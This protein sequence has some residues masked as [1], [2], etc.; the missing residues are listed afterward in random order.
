MLSR[1]VLKE[2]GWRVTTDGARALTG[3][4]IG[5][6]KLMDNKIKEKHPDHTLLPLHCVIHQE[7]LCKAALNIKHVID[8]IVSVINLIRARGL[9]HRQFRGL[10]EDLETEHS[11]I[12]YHSS[13]RW[14]S[15]GKIL[16]RMWDL[17]EEIV[18]L[19]EM[20]DIDCDFVSNIVNEE[21]KTD[22]V[23]H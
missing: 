21:W 8:P 20:K 6:L 4:N 14:L 10:L 13:V 1:T 12:L 17:K 19:L 18:M 23:C 7:S 22:H 5:L 16:R 2:L 3:K 11:D 9:N 15:L